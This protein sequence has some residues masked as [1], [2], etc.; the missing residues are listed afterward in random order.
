[1]KNIGWFKVPLIECLVLL[2]VSCSQSTTPNLPNGTMPSLSETA[3][4]IETRP[5]PASPT[6]GDAIQM[7][8]TP[9]TVS[10]PSLQS[11]IEKAREDLAQRLSISVNEII[12]LE[13]TSVVWPDASLGCPQEGM[14]FAQVLTPGYLI[15]L[16]SGNQE[17]EYHA[18]RGTYIIYCENPTPPIP[19]TPADI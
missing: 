3:Q 6:E 9:P 19:G 11:L 16:E 15:R 17:F 4:V 14:E 8:P 12:L 10:N 13:V 18:S 5:V 1:M 7:T 2:L